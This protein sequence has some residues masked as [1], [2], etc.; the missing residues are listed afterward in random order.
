MFSFSIDGKLEA[1][2]R[3]ADRQ[4]MIRVIPERPIQPFRLDEEPRAVRIYMDDSV[5]VDRRMLYDGAPLHVEGEV[6]HVQ[7]IVTKREFGKEKTSRYEND[8]FIGKLLRSL[9]KVK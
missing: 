6:S 2:Q 9:D 7:R 1:I 3:G 5:E 4:L 8:H